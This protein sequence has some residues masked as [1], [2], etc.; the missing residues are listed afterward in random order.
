MMLTSPM[1]VPFVA[2]STPQ[3]WHMD[4]VGGVHPIAYRKNVR[5]S[6]ESLDGDVAGGSC[7]RPHGGAL[8]RVRDILGD[9]RDELEKALKGG[10]TFETFAA[11]LRP[12]LQAKGWWGIR[13]HNPAERQSVRQARAGPVLEELQRW[14]DASLRRVPGRS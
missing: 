11:N 5:R 3:P 8:G 9:I 14:L 4:A 6:G 2:T 12:T 1:D 13:G 7:G 10:K